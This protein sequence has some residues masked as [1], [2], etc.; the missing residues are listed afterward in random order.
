MVDAAFGGAVDMATLAQASAGKAG[1]KTDVKKEPAD[2]FWDN[3]WLKAPFM[4][5]YWGGRPAATQ[6]LGVAYKSDAPWNET[7][8]KN[9]KFDK[10]LADARAEIDVGKRKDYIWA[11]Q[12][13]LHDEGGCLI[14]AFRDWIDAHNKKV[15][16][17]TPHSGF[18]IDNG[19]LGEKAWLKA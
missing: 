7:H 13:M 4:T 2:G 15:G 6:M 12:A 17:H 16:G 5:G 8:W 9:E 11:M 18:D 19:R 10:L 1:I 3:V 14:P